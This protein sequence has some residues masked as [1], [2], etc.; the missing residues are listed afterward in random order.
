[1]PTTPKQAI[2]A[3]LSTD[4]QDSD[5]GHLGNLLGHTSEAPYGVFFMHPPERPDFPLITYHE[6]AGAGRMP[7]TDIFH[8]TVWTKIDA[9]EAIHELIYGLLHEQII[10]SDSGV[11]IVDL[12]W[13]W[14][15]PA[16]YDDNFHVYAQTHR[17]IS[18]GVKI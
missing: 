2:Y 3:A 4:A 18:K 8:I 17:Y 10:T 7:R 12:M 6:V 9:Y 13:N 1:M 15:G 14:S 16:V 5:A 11:F